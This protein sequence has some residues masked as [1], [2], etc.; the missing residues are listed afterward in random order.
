MIVLTL[1]TAVVHLALGGGM[2]GV[3]AGGGF[4]VGGPPGGFQP[5]SDGQGPD[6][7]QPPQNGPPPGGAPGGTGFLLLPIL[8]VLNGIG[9]LA[10][11]ALLVLPVPY[12]RQHP[13]VSHWVLI[14][15]TALT[16]VLYFAINSFG[17]FLGNPMAIVSKA[18]ELLLIICAFLHWR[19]VRSA[20]PAPVQKAGA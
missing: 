2:I 6:G 20:A 14:G 16:F 9:Y 11:L 7:G 10:L 4:P 8:F 17:R 3:V 19:A 18:A 5:P 12:L 1:I 13:G 15:Y